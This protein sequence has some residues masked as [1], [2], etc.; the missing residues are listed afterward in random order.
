MPKA[1]ILSINIRAGARHERHP[2]LS[3]RLQK[4]DEVPLRLC[5]AGKIQS[6][7]FWLMP[8]PGNVA[9]KSVKTGC[10]QLLQRRAPEF[11]P[12]TKILKFACPQQPGLTIQQEHPSRAPKRAIA[13]STSQEK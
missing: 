10:P 5:L 4:S 9:G 2:R 11:G 8:N 6:T 7:F 1:T 13:V 12:N 3:A